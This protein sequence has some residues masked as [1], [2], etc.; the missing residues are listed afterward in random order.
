MGEPLRQSNPNPNSKNKHLSNHV[1]EF[2]CPHC[3][4]RVE[5]ETKD[6]NCEIFRHGVYRATGEAIPPHAPKAYCENVVA[7]NLIYGCGKP[8]RFDG[9]NPKVCD[10][11]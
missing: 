2:D 4:G 7:K 3:G 8:F 11:I 6:I 10:Y 9:K 5:V 1:F